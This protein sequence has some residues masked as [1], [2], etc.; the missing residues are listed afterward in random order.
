M[1][2]GVVAAVATFFGWADGANLTP[3]VVAIGAAVATA[4]LTFVVWLLE[5]SR[6]RALERDTKSTGDLVVAERIRVLTVTNGAFLTTLQSL[7]L[8][9]AMDAAGRRAE[10]SGFRHSV[11]NRV[12]DLVRNEQP[13]AAY[14]K[15]E[16]LG[17][18]VRVMRPA[19]YIAQRSRTDEFTTE[20]NEAS[21]A[22]PDVW[23]LVD[24]H[25]DAV[26]RD[27]VDQPGKAY[28]SYISAPVRCGGIAFGML[29][30]NVLEVG[31]LTL[32]DKS[33]VLVLARLLAVAELM[34][35]TPKQRGDLARV[36]R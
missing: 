5:E 6:K 26:M 28:K 33:F 4:I 20:F 21:G 10:I 15:V 16:D 31:G 11:V 36:V 12:C 2:A 23:P 14:F 27:Q 18:P 30:V 3:R 35:L 24:S 1:V 29:T 25:E 34:S 8:F 7:Q 32:E 13:R 19:P 17:A 9:A 22:E